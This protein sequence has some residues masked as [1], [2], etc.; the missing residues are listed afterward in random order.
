MSD[1]EKAAQAL[2][3]TTEQLD[4]RI[5]KY[6]RRDMVDYHHKTMGSKARAKKN[7]KYI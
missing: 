6:L 7:K 1:Y 5:A 2:G 3:L 4:A